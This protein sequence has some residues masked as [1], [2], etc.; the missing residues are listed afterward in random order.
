MLSERRSRQVRYAVGIGCA[1]ALVA[2]FA[3]ADYVWPHQARFPGPATA[4]GR[5]LDQQHQ[6]EEAQLRRQQRAAQVVLRTRT[7]ALLVV[8]D[9]LTQGYGATDEDTKDYLA[10]T[11]GWLRGHGE[12]PTVT[13]VHASGRTIGETFLQLRAKDGIDEAVRGVDLAVVELGTNNV[14]TGTSAAA[15]QYRRLLRWIHA[16]APEAQL[17]CLGTWGDPS[18]TR[19]YDD[20]IADACEAAGGKFHALSQLYAVHGNRNH[21][22]TLPNGRTVD[23]FH[24]SDQGYR[25]I[26]KVVEQAIRLSR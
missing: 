14:G 18:R 6:D 2:I 22:G 7:P 11:V 25:Q 23:S 5:S 4:A 21:A 12:T 13:D 16:H 19:E 1:V 9:S 24:P 10:L 3:Y 8:G 20:A 26:A 17:L 15:R